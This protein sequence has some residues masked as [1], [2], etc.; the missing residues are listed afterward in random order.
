MS[1]EAR[2][3]ALHA[4]TGV[5][6]P[7]VLLVGEPAATLA[8]AAGAAAL[9]VLEVGRLRRPAWAAALD[10]ALP[11]VVRPAEARRVSGAFLLVAGYVLASALFAPRPAA[12]GILA[13]ALGDAAAA[14][15]GRR[16]GGARAAAGRRTHVGSVACF[17]V[18]AVAVALV[19]GGAWR[20]A[21]AAALAATVLE[22]AAPAGV[23]N[24]LMPAGT[25]AV[26]A[27]LL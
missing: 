18:T 10:R 26:V 25:A 13:L 24:L 12:A 7:W 20:V 5:A 8:L 1:G 15:A 17:V 14:L 3:K 23:D 19:L 22:R 16:W 6:A 11:G 21:G 2:R 4:A 9:L 27:T